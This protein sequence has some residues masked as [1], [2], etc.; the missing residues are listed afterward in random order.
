PSASYKN[1]QY[2][3]SG[4]TNNGTWFNTAMLGLQTVISWT[5]GMDVSWT[6]TDRLTFSAGYM[7]ESI[8]QKQ[9]NRNNG[10]NDPSMD[11]VSDNTDQ[12]NTY[13]ASMKATLIP[14]KLV[15]KVGAAYSQAL[16]RVQQYSPNATGSTVYNANQP[17]DVTWRWPA[18]YNQLARLDAPVDYTFAKTWTAKFCYAYERFGRPAPSPRLSLRTA[19]VRSSSARTGRTTPPKSS[20]PVSSTSSSSAFSECSIQRLP[21]AG[22]PAVGLESVSSAL[23]GERPRPDPDLPSC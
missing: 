20:A 16:G 6:P 13:T 18:F 9:R 14:D 17:N 15:F 22:K 7:Y 23:P 12:F 1:T 8:F 2:I 3:A 5:A 21:A 11:W 19:A 10:P 4:L